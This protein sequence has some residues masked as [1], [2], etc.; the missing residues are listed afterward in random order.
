MPIA[1]IRL[2]IGRSKDS[3]R[4]KEKSMS[5]RKHCLSTI[6]ASALIFGSL[7]SARAQGEITLLASSPAKATIDKVVAGFEAKSG[8]KVK[9]T[10]LGYVPTRT[11]VAQG[12][13]LDV[14]LLAAPYPG[15]VASG[16]I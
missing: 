2:H 12:K 1:E 10:Y 6:F 4:A 3:R 13:G 7:V 11:S 15:A 16:T 5:M 8:L 14:D 9:V